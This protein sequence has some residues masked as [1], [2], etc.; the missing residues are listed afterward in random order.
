MHLT[1][2]AF[3]IDERASKKY[4]NL[5]FGQWLQHIDAAAREQGGV[6][7]EGRVFCRRSDQADA[8]FFDMRQKGVLLRLVEA[9]NFVDEDDG[10]RAVLA[11]AGGVAYYPLDFLDAREHSRKFDKVSL[12]DAGN[13]FGESSFAC[14]RRAPEDHRRRIIAFDLHAQRF[15]RSDQMLLP[16][17]FVERA[18]THA[19]RQR[20]CLIV[21]FL[22]RAGL[23]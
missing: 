22:R 8:A 9:V 17:K 12:C 4:N 20:T 16:N 14:T 10:A 23:E 13:N 2:A 1:E 21:G 15:A 7:F 18:R 6:D 5:I 19:I 11:G 3:F